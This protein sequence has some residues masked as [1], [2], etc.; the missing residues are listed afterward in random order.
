[1]EYKQ[2]LQNPLMDQAMEKAKEEKMEELR[3]Q[4]RIRNYMNGYADSMALKCAVENGI[5][6]IIQKH[7][8]PIAL[9]ELAKALPLPTVSTE[10]LER[11]MKYWVQLGLFTHEK[12]GSHGLTRCSKYLLRE[13]NTTM[14][15]IILGLVTE[16]TIGP[17]HCLARSLE[18]GP[19]AFRRYHGRDM[20]DYVAGHPE[21]SR[22]FNESMAG[23]TRLLLPVLMQECG[24]WLFE[25]ISSLVDVGGGN[26]TAMVEIA[27]KFPGIKCTVF[28]LPHVI[29]NTNSSESTGVEWV[30][31]DMFESIPPADAVLLREAIPKER[32]KVIIIDIVMDIEQDPEL[33]RAKL[34]TDIDMMVYLTGK[35]R[36]K[37]EW[38]KL[39]QAA[40]YT[41]YQTTPIFPLQSVIVAYP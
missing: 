13:E 5:A 21:A 27:K 29:R 16:W 34:M 1:M 19:T 18:G 8:K 7:A 17:W 35:E 32:G 4:V 20:W 40:G 31:G 24:S 22:L 33:I 12:D 25:G 41:K 14:A 10:H 3:A 38:E 39:V 15:A 36:T 28:D 9:S 23:D 6:D 30:E 26:G 37:K 2:E 11:L